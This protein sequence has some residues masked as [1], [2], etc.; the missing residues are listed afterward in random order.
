MEG[1]QGFCE[2]FFQRSI[3]N[4]TLLTSSDSN[5]PL[6]SSPC[7]LPSQ[8]SR[9]LITFTDQS[10]QI[11]LSHHTSSSIPTISSSFSDNELFFYQ[12]FAHLSSAN[13]LLFLFSIPSPHHGSPSSLEQ[14]KILIFNDLPLTHPLTS[15]PTPT[16]PQLNLL[17]LKAAVIELGKFHC[18]YF[19]HET[20]PPK[21]IPSASALFTNYKYQEAYPKFVETW[22]NLLEEYVEENEKKILLEVFEHCSQHVSNWTI[23]LEMGPPSLVHG[24]YQPDNLII[25]NGTADATPSADIF[26]TLFN[27]QSIFIGT[28]PI[29]PSLPTSLFSSSAPLHVGGD[30]GRAA[31]LN[32]LLITSLDQ[33]MRSANEYSFVSFYLQSLRENI[34]KWSPPPSPQLLATIPSEG[35]FGFYLRMATQ[36]MV[37]H[38]LRHYS[39]IDEL[40]LRRIFQ[41]ILDHDL[42]RL[43]AVGRR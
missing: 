31:D 42:H 36:G 8:F 40:I 39:S 7:L 16:A 2:E 20:A 12:K 22:R 13:I 23:L 24:N 11:I 10:Q 38:C 29:S 14:G 26:V 34:L 21:E 33:N 18:S 17:H 15:L 43:L 1:C 3:E 4:F 32:S 28:L 6:S 37:Y 35:E 30:V 5:L 25:H 27:F 19:F 41:A 9:Y